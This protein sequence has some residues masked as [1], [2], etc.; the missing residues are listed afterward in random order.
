MKQDVSIVVINQTYALNQ[1]LQKAEP[2]RICSD[3]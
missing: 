2:A 3:R 1:A